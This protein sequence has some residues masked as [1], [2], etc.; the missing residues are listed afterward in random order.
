M[1]LL[2]L[3]HN[4]QDVQNHILNYFQDNQMSYKTTEI[5]WNQLQET[6]KKSIQRKIPPHTYPQPAQKTPLLPTPPVPARPQIRE[7]LIPGLPPYSNSQYHYKEYISGPYSTINNK[8]HPPLLHS[9]PNQHTVWGSQRTIITG[10]LLHTNWH[11]PP[12]VPTKLPI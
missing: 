7:Q 11:Y 10:P 1:Q 6:V 5:T 8:Q 9:P 12:R 2:P 4:V 3:K